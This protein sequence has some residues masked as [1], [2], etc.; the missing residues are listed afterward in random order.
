ME[1]TGENMND[2]INRQ[3]VIDLVHKTIFEFFEY[4][5]EPM[6]EQEKMLLEINKAICNGI[7]DLPSK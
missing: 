6:N 7:K 3:D 4:G 2:L 1:S 5:D